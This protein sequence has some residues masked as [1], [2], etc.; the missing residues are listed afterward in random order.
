ME[1][2][3]PQQ[4]K[5]LLAQIPNKNKQERF[6]IYQQV[7]STPPYHNSLELDP[8]GAFHEEYTQLAEEL[9]DR[10]NVF[11]AWKDFVILYED[12]EVKYSKVYNQAMLALE[13]EQDVI[14]CLRLQRLKA[15]HLFIL[16]K[17]KQA[18]E[19][20]KMGL[21][22]TK[23]LGDNELIFDYYYFISCIVSENRED[24][25]RYSKEALRYVTPAKQITAWMLEGDMAVQELKHYEAKKVYSKIEEWTIQGN[26]KYN[27]Q[28]VY[29]GM[30]QAISIAGVDARVDKT[31]YPK[32]EQTMKEYVKK[33]I[34]LA[35]ELGNWQNIAESHLRMANFYNNFGQH[36]EA[37]HHYEIALAFAEQ[38]GCRKDFE[39]DIYFYL[40][41]N[42]KKIGDF[43]KA[44]QAHEKYTALKEEMYTLETQNK[45]AELNTTFEAEKREEEIARLKKE[46]ELLDTIK[47][48]NLQLA[49]LNQ[50]KDRIFSIIAHDMRKPAI[51]FRGIARK[52]SYLLKKQDYQTL[53]RISS[54]IEQD[55]LALHQLTDNLLHWAI[56]QKDVLAYHPQTLNLS[57]IVT[58][59][60]ALFQRVAT[61]K[62]I[63][64]SNDVP[65]HLQVHADADALS[66]IVRN[67]ID[68]AI[69]YTSNGGKV[70]ITAQTTPQGIQL[71]ISDT[72]KGIPQDKLKDIFLLQKDK[73]TVGTAGEKGTGLGLHLTHE[74]VKLNKGIIKVVSQLG[75][76]TTCK[77]VFPNT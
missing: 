57:H 4:A 20:L 28:F 61:E 2:L 58:E 75:K 35:K 46:T 39:K 51:T 17:V 71:Q 74:L 44:L 18:V 56:L 1:H 5:T 25:I 54:E 40:Y 42:S 48:Q 65:N 50:T 31:E 34:A 11:K 45:I 32:L 22:S 72:G 9:G 63:V 70:S 12:D 41:E 26:N 8:D 3:N 7:F 73:S 47:A 30:Q 64:C 37:I 60:S 76:G 24:R 68:N 23:C 38:Y 59:T 55:A 29:I 15:K 52:V 16:G 66:I 19:L 21:E 49:Q 14:Y 36:K 53:N 62:N 43:Q 67:L 69:K 33:D 13:Q 10:E 77:I 6:E 27:L